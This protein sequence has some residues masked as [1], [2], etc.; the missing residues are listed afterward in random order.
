MQ[1]YD[2]AEPPPDAVAPDGRA[3][4]FLNAPAESANIE[5]IRTKKNREFTNHS[6]PPLPI[7]CVI[8]GASHKAA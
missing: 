3:Q 8:L 5:A 6:A 2:F 1:P 7:H 4:R